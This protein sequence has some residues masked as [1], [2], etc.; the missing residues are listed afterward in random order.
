MRDAASSASGGKLRRAGLGDVVIVA[1]IGGCM[2]EASR[3][4]IPLLSC[5]HG[6]VKGVLVWTVPAVLR[7]EGEGFWGAGGL[8]VSLLAV[9]LLMLW[10]AL[11]C[12]VWAACLKRAEARHLCRL[13]CTV[14]RKVSW[15]GR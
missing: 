4:G 12:L 9:L 15:F 1:F 6:F 13:V 2:F 3:R 10:R 11:L 5:V 7:V 8:Q 14:S